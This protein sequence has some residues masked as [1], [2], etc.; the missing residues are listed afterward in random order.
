MSEADWTT[1]PGDI[2][3]DVP[4]EQFYE[5]PD[6]IAPDDADATAQAQ[7][8]F[9]EI[10]PGTHEL[11]IT[12]FY[13]DPVTKYTKFEVKDP[14]TGSKRTI[15]YPVTKRTLKIAMVANPKASMFHD[16]WLPP[17]DPE[18]AL[19]YWHG[20]PEGKKAQGFHAHSFR[21]LI[22]AAIAPWLQGQPIPRMAKFEKNWVGRRF[23]ATVDPPEPWVN[24]SG[25]Q[26]PGSIKIN[27]RSFRPA[28]GQPPLTGQSV[29]G[30]SGPGTGQGAGTATRP[31]NGQGG[32]PATHTSQ[33]SAASTTPTGSAASPPG[34]WDL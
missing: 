3:F 26:Q 25:V 15:G 19:A 33:P 5:I 32:R 16:V 24:D 34:G 8:G 29:P 20:I 14:Q 23:I 30:T 22:S 4:G 7:S 12:G 17:A 13:K 28:P 21:G 11:F 31:P 6:T 2:P 27:V 18:H 10:P 1:E 9:S